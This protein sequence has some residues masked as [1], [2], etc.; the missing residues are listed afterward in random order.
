MSTYILAI[1]QGTTGTT[2]MILSHEA[3]VIAR[4]SA[5]FE[6]RYPQP[7]WV[8][9]DPEAIWGSLRTALPKALNQAG[10]K[11][12]Q[13]EGIGITNQR[14]TALMWDRRD[15]R[16]LHHA[17]VWQDRRTASH[18]QTLNEEGHEPLFRQ[19]TGLLLDPYFSGTKYRWLLDHVDGARSLAADG[20]VALGTV[21]SYLLHRLTGGAAHM[22]DVT[23]ACRSLLFDIHT[24]SWDQELCEIMQVPS[25]AL[26]EVSDSASVFGHTQGLDILPDGIP[27]AAMAGDQHAALFG[28]TCFN[29]GDAKCTYGTGAFLLMN[30]GERAIASEHGLLSTIAWRYRGQTCYALEGSAFIAGA[31]VQWLRDG[32]G[33]I[34]HSSEVEDLAQSV[35]STGDVV[36][37]PALAGLGA[38]HWDPQARGMLWGLTRDS[39]KGH[40][41]RAVLE[42]IAMQIV[43]LS[44][45]IEADA[46]K[47]M[48][49]MRVDGGASQNNLLMQVQ[50]NLLNRAVVRPTEIET[51]ALGAGYLAGLSLGVFPDLETVRKLH[52]IERRFEPKMSSAA[53]DYFVERWRHAIVRARRAVS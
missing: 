27:I 6:Q 17:I 26:P 52:Q 42:G 40:I 23:N 49:Y 16:S 30:T 25:R 4:A 3:K 19:R 45:A 7:S 21:D 51:T 28:Q 35:S 9:H 15:G 14:E 10:I 33:I 8:E 1:D 37:V 5:E 13:I 29:E 36:F 38:P 47:Q 22:T 41:A 18:C 12:S 46:G 20:H 50:S 43:D 44:Y 39:H 48:N 2:V 31:A 11:A 34:A 32:L 53:R 24:L